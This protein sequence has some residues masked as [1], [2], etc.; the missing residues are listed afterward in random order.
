MYVTL[1]YNLGSVS[2]SRSAC[3]PVDPPFAKS[4]I[5]F[6]QMLNDYVALPHGPGAPTTSFGTTSI[7]EANFVT[8][9]F[10]LQACGE[11]SG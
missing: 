1:V 2:G 11:V 5:S 7:R 6:Q 3:E 9:Q 8:M 10:P 4:Q